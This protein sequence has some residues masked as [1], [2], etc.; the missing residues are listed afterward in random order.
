[1]RGVCVCLKQS[2]DRGLTWKERQNTR[3]WREKPQKKTKKEKAK[4]KIVSEK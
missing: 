3:K 1:V 4:P 2:I